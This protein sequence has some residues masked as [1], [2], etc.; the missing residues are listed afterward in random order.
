MAY[1]C[2]LYTSYYLSVGYLNNQGVKIDDDYTSIRANMK[3]NMNV[4]KYLEV[5]ANVNFQN[6]SDGSI[7][8]DED[9]QMRN[10]P[11]ADYKDA[12][13]NLV[14]YPLDG[15]Y[16]QRGY[17]YE[18]QKQYLELE[19]GYTTFNTVFDAK[20]KLPFGITY[21]FNIAPRF[22]WFYDRYFMSA[23]L[24]GSVATD[25]GVNREQAKR[26]D[27]SLNNTINW[28]YTLDVY[29]RQLHRK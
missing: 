16:S 28:D 17:N 7:G 12:D 20:L 9:Y 15:S 22:Q 4:N 23:D 21:T 29:K 13:G 3:V 25:R 5:G 8:V 6:R 18:F 2:L 27:Y 14:Q 1:Y 11:Y 10:C 24:P 26:F 19:K